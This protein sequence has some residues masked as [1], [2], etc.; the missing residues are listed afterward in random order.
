MN[1]CPTY[2][3]IPI[4]PLFGAFAIETAMYLTA[5]PGSLGPLYKIIVFDLDYE[6]PYRVKVPYNRVLDTPLKQSQQI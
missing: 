6:S 2:L 5:Y 1:S 4:A 3:E